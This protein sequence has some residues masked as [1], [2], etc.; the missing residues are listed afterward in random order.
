MPRRVFEDASFTLRAGEEAGWE[1]TLQRLYRLGYARVDVVG[2]A[3]EY[4]VRGGILDVFPATADQPVRVE[5][6]G[7]EIDSVRPFA[8][9]SQ[10]STGTLDAVAITPWLEILRDRR[11]RDNV[12]ARASGEANVISALRAYLAGGADVPEPWLSLAYDERATILDYLHDE[13]LVVLEEPGMLET[14]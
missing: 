4:A 14:V 1:R 12:L 13:S 9:Q 10:R 11:L 6:F 8:L 7:D 3:G 5:F 2:A